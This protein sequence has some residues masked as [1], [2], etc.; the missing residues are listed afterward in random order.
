MM[1]LITT[2]SGKYKNIMVEYYH[3]SKI[4]GFYTV[5]CK[6]SVNAHKKCFRIITKDSDII[7]SIENETDTDK[8]Q[9]LYHRTYYSLFK[10]N[11]VEWIN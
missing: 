8:K 11:V 7:K 4:H 5:F 2:L 3:T 6:V 1:V 10:N 9:L